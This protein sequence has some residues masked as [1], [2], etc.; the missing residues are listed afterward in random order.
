MKKLVYPPTSMCRPDPWTSASL[1]DS[2]AL[3]SS[4]H[5]SAEKIGSRLWVAF[6]QR[7]V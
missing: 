7:S 6:S 5:P 1:I 3:V 4:S 2:G